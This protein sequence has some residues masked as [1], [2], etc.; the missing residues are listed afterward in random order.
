MLYIYYIIFKNNKVL[1]N[2]YYLMI[3]SLKLN[4]EFYCKLQM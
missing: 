1:N 3:K 2:A 4:K